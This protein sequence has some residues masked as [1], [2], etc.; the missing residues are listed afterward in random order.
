MFRDEWQLSFLASFACLAIGMDLV[1]ES[2]ACRDIAKLARTLH[3]GLD[4]L[5]MQR[6]L[7]E[8]EISVEDVI[9][10]LESHLLKPASIAGDART[11]AIGSAI[12]TV[13]E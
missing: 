10:V 11:N 6:G 8:A 7:F 5:F 13:Q 2:V 1:S 9:E 4:D 12:A 3:A